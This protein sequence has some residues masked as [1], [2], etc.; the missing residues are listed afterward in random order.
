MTVAKFPLLLWCA[1]GLAA[2]SSTDSA[3]G[4]IAADPSPAKTTPALAPTPSAASEAA[5]AP[6]DLAGE[7]LKRL[8]KAYTP[9]M[10]ATLTD[11]FIED[12]AATDADHSDTSTLWRAIMPNGTLVTPGTSGTLKWNA[13]GATGT[14]SPQLATSVTSQSNGSTSASQQYK[15]LTAALGVT[16]PN[17]LK[18][19]GM[20][21]H[22]TT[23]ERGRFY[24]RN[25]GERLPIRGGNWNDGGDAGV[26]ALNL[27]NA[28]SNASTDFGF[29][30]AFV[31]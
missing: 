26:F 22:D 2:C 20:F 23:I 10:L 31:I 21:P 19:L 13:T 25:E 27:S 6:I 15:D 4:P 17:L 14:G 18:L 29:R 28:R 3:P 7:A 9:A 30:P 12:T 24:M 16:V 1:V 11:L 5:R 8:G